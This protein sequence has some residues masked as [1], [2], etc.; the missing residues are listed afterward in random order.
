MYVA[1]DCVCNI[2]AE[3]TLFA[4]RKF[5]DD[6]WN[7]CTIDEFFKRCNILVP[8]FLQKYVYVPLLQKRLPKVVAKYITLLLSSL[9]LEMVMVK[10]IVH[11]ADRHSCSTCRDCT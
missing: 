1:F 10:L 6:Y 11:T 8:A 9:L 3:L 5:Y 7:S 4:D 2:F